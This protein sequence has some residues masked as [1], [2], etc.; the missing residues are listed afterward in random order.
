MVFF[1][2][3]VKGFRTALRD[4][5]EVIRAPV[6]LVLRP[7]HNVPFLR[8]IVDV[9]EVGVDL[10]DPI[11]RIETVIDLGEKVVENPEVFA[12]LVEGIGGGIETI[13]FITQQP[14]LIAAGFGIKTVGEL[15]EPASAVI[16]SAQEGD[17]SGVIS[18]LGG[19]GSQLANLGKLEEA[20]NK[21]LTDISKH[22]VSVGKYIKDVDEALAITNEL[23]NKTVDADVTNTEQLREFIDQN[24]NENEALKHGQVILDNDLQALQR[25]E[26]KEE[27]VL[28][29]IRTA[30]DNPTTNS[31]FVK[32]IENFNNPKAILEYLAENLGQVEGLSESEMNII[33]D[34]A[35]SRGVLA[36]L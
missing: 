29:Q 34:L 6:D 20:E 23:L 32:D 3:F 25:E 7:L 33:L 28:N 31:D 18:G 26:M 17:L 14:E 24:H 10:I 16:V 27:D 30:I 13:G 15:I 36:A 9:I 1:N 21:K 8:P 2:D 35:L 11:K 4:I 12:K 5:D 19:L 22:L